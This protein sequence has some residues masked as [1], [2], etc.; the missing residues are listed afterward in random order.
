MKIKET[1]PR[2]E[3]CTERT[4]GG[5]RWFVLH[6]PESFYSNSGRSVRRTPSPRSIQPSNEARALLLARRRLGMDSSER[7]IIIM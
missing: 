2:S 6:S 5:R 3:H 4:R 7:S 1:E